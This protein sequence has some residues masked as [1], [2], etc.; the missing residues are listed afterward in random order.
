LAIEIRNPRGVRA[1]V[2]VFYENG[3]EM[4]ELLRR[5]LLI[6]PV[7]VLA[8]FGGAT[9]SPAQAPAGKAKAAPAPDAKKAAEAKAEEPAEDAQ[10]Q[11]K[12][13]KPSLH[14][15]D[16]W[17]LDFTY[18]KVAT[19]Q[20]TDGVRRGEVYWYMLYRIENKTGKDREAYLSIT[21]RSDHDKSYANI[22]LPDVEPRI[23]EKLGKTLWGKV[24]EVN[25]LRERAEKGE[26]STD[27]VNFNY[28]TF[29]A[30]ETRDCVAIFN[31]LDPGATHL[32]IT[33]DGLSNDRPVIQREGGPKQIESRIYAV[34]LER[35]GDEYAMNLDTFRLV[36]AGTGWTKK[37]TELAPPKKG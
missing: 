21:A 35:P 28:I 31:K 2:G 8:W 18:Q 33:V 30:G 15:S 12:V 4:G 13:A 37:L 10:D 32:T 1:A 20:P 23:E 6:V 14:P 9:P 17:L 7:L 19:F 29:K 22:C 25:I 24:D 26:T 3:S 5:G 36:K 34:K 11:E 16:F 27:K